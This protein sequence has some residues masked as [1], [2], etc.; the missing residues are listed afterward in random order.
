MKRNNASS[1]KHTIAFYA[2]LVS[3]LICLPWL[4]AREVLKKRRKTAGPP[5]RRRPPVAS[6]QVYVCVHEW[7]GYPMRRQKT[8]KHGATFD[9]GLEAQLERFSPYRASG[10]VEL[11]VTLSAADRHPDL[12]AIRNRTDHLILSCNKGMDFSGYAAFFDRIK[13]KPDAYVILTNSSVNA[14]QND[15]LESYIRCM[16][17][18]PDAGLVAP[19]TVYPDGE[20]QYLCKLLPTPFDL[21]LRRFLPAGFLKSSRERFELRFTGYDREMNVPFLSG[22]FM[23]LRIGTLKETGL[24]DERYFMY[25]EDID[26]SRRI[27]RITRTVYCPDA[28][29]VHAH[30][31][32]SRKN[33][34]ML[35]IHIGSLVKYFNKWG[36]IID[37]ERRRANRACIEAL[38]GQGRG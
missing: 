20:T 21:I 25:A 35:L 22:C 38:K 28:V 7:G 26:F 16:D 31:A 24:F 8:I 9:C 1:L 17:R 27:H 14:A 13:N 36:W 11:T 6:K 23:F 5:L 32:A 33:G 10:R 3:E 30:E 2:L 15:F 18:H 34:K 19:K 4:S 29:V 37:R 12:S